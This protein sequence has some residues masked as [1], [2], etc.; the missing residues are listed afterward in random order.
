VIY[1]FHCHTFLS[2]GE[3]LPTEL[4]RR[5]I[6]RDYGVVAFTDHASMGNCENIL[7]QVTADAHVVETHWRVTAIPGVEITHV[8]AT[9]LAEIA[10]HARE[11][12]AVLVNVH[13]ETIA[14][15]VEPGT[16]RAAVTSPDVDILAHPGL[17]TEE[18]AR[19]A[20][21]NNVFLEITTRKGHCL[22][23]GHV[24]RM[25]LRA[26]ARLLLNTDSHA[27]GDLLSEELAWKTALGA[28]L[29][30]DE[31]RMVLDENPKL[32]LE[33]LMP[34]LRALGLGAPTV[35]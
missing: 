13:G 28:G 25:A 35:R 2:D 29:A 34:R 12:G 30:E 20:A 18:E 11:K 15:P 16:N 3:L 21:K 26:G 32:L 24:A 8:P 7:R 27:P 5:A 1:D 31:V 10:R 14:E 6:I 33:R 19:L 23:N 17:I 22:T 4:A 9:A